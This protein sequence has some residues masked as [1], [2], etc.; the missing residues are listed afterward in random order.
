MTKPPDGDLITQV[1]PLELVKQASEQSEVLRLYDK[2]RRVSVRAMAVASSAWLRR[3]ALTFVRRALSGIV[4]DEEQKERASGHERQPW[5]RL[6]TELLAGVDV[7]SSSLYFCCTATTAIYIVNSAVAPM[8]Y[9]E[10]HATRLGKWTL[11]L[12][13]HITIVIGCTK[14]LCTI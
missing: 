9:F 4:N 2:T 13:R 11:Y 14:K 7:Q 1:L 8:Q 10:R 3:E 6:C 12:M 5:L